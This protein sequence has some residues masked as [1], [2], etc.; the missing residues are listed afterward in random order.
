[1]FTIFVQNSNVDIWLGFEYAC[2]TYEK[3]LI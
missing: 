1:M 3:F 2:G